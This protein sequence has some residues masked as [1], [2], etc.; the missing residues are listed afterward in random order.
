MYNLSQVEFRDSETSQLLTS[1]A[2]AQIP[3]VGWQLRWLNDVEYVVDRV[4]LEFYEVVFYEDETPCT[5]V[6]F[7]A[8]VF[9][10]L[11]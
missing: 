4:G 1:Q 7:K 3:Q 10:S 2:M 8:H 11:A 5:A 6:K 9:V